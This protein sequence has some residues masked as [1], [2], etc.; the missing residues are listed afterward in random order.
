[1]KPAP[2]ED[3]VHH[4]AGIDVGGTTIKIGIVT[5]K[6]DVVE[7]RNIAYASMSSFEGIADSLAAALAAAQAASGLRIRSIGLAAPGHARPSD[8]LMV[9][10]TA[11]VPLL[12]NR[13]LALALRQRMSLPV[14]TINDGSAA[15]FGELHF[16]AG[17]GLRRFCVI[18]LGTGVGGGIVINRKLV[19]GEGGVPPELGAMVLHDAEPG[20]RTLEEFASAGGFTT[21]YARAGGAADATPLQICRFLADGDPIARQV[22]D[23]ICRRIAQALGALINALNLEACILS[24]GIAQAGQMLTSRI[25]DQLS[26]FTWPFLCSRCQVLPGQTGTI[27]GII[28]AAEWSRGFSEEL[29]TAPGAHG[30]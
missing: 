18:T 7:R 28:G 19:T 14:A 13:S 9:D 15:T 8:G 5:P 24:G 29:P 20:N 3:A 4:A 2:S 16:G 1:M 12:R 10:G 27:S 11:N 23:R 21:A 6:G 22:V 26:D 30:R 17:R 25:A